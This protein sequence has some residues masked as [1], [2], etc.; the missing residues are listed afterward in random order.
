MP[1][2]VARSLA[3]LKSVPYISDMEQIP[4]E[5]FRAHL[6]N[7][8]ATRCRHN[9]RYSL[10]SFAKVIQLDPSSLSQILSGKRKP[11]ARMMARICAQVGWPMEYEPVPKNRSDY[12]L[13]SQ[14]AFTAISD[15]YHYALLDLTLL[16]GFRSDASWIAKRLGISKFEA[17][18]AVERLKRLG[19]LIEKNGRLEKAE[20]L[21]ANYTE[22]HTSAAHKEYQRQIIQK[23][24]A[25]IDGCEPEEKDI[26]CITIAADTKKLKAAKEKIKKFRRELCAFLENGEGD[27]VHV[28]AVQLFPL[29]KRGIS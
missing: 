24:L 19:M 28:L 26:T 8:L 25:A 15:W 23:A 29:T 5:V 1:R 7:Q 14:D 12:F 16:K 20:R 22:G 4:S 18:M 3:F 27:S 17:Q 13:L 9:S 11:S 6:R 21:Y 10:R 2:F